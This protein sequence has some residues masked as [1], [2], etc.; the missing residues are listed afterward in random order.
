MTINLFL[1]ANSLLSFYALSNSD[2]E[3]LKQPKKEGLRN[4]TQGKKSVN[5][6][7]NSTTKPSAITFSSNFQTK[8]H[9]ID[10]PANNRQNA[11]AVNL[12]VFARAWLIRNLA[13]GG[14]SFDADVFPS[15]TKATTRCLNSIPC[16]LPILNFLQPDLAEVN[17]ILHALG[18]LNRNGSNTL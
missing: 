17:Q 4:A 6:I 1:D 8:K 7:L 3:Q 11:R 16:G 5:L 15:S 10:Y 14:D 18:I 2:I 9:S 12:F 13:Q